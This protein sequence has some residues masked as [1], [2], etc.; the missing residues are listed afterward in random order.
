MTTHAASILVVDD[1]ANICEVRTVLITGS[2]ADAEPSIQRS[3]KSASTPFA[4][5]RLTF[6]SS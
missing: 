3:V 2:R 6:P 1:D 4:T 5:S